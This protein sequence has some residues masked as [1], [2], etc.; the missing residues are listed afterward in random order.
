MSDRF[1]QIFYF[2][3]F[4]GCGDLSRKFSISVAV[5]TLFIGRNQIRLN[6][7]D[8]TN[9]YAAQMLRQTSISEGTLITS[10]YQSA[11]RGQRSNVWQ[12]EPKKN[13]L[14]TYIL[15][16]TWLGIE[17]QFTLNKSI[18]LAVFRAIRKYYESSDLKIKWPNDIF[19]GNRK[20]AGILME[21]V[22]AGSQIVS[23]LAGIGINVNQQNMSID[24]RNVVSIADVI[25]Q[26]ISLDLFQDEL[27]SQ[28]EAVYL[29]LRRGNDEKIDQE[30]TLELFK[31]DEECMFETPAGLQRFIVRKVSS[32][33]LLIV[34]DMEGNTLQF[35]H[36]EVDM[37]FNYF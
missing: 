17:R 26:P 13:I 4:A 10:N 25:K 3:S 18:A 32:H 16:P 36:G 30:F 34:E 1:E 2:F 23:S 31:R 27:S 12:S 8:S 21:N 7:I 37:L 11:G 20:V 28:I 33:G 6:C 29:C 19:I 22:V 9:N 15:K 24:G 5:K 14:C 35:N